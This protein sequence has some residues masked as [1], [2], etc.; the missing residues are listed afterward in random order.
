MNNKILI[1]QVFTRLY[2]NRNE[3]RKQWGTYTENGSGKFNDFDRTTLKHIKDMGFSHIWFTGVLRHATQTD[4]SAYNIP[5]Q[6]PAVVKGKA[7]S[8]Y[9]ICD[10]YDVDPDLAVNVD[11]RMEEFESLVS[12]AHKLGLKVII[13]FVP[14]HVA[15]Q[16]KSIAKPEGVKDLGR[17]DNV[18]DGFNPHNN[19][20]YCPESILTHTS[21]CAT[22]LQVPSIA[23]LQTCNHTKS[24]RQNLPATTALPPVLT[25]M[26]G[27][28]R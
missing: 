12:R 27:M 25:Q 7:G 11:K 6:H 21:T 5:R 23:T 16:Y 2:G 9:A 3:T 10:Y 22:V 19:F 4:Y 14:N 24:I 1:Y 17:D 15:R 26:T 18:S 20:Y 8:P 13:D 28:R